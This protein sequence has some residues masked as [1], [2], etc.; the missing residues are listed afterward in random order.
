MGKLK[1]AIARP[2]AIDITLRDQAWRKRLAAWVSNVS[3]PP[4]ITSL[5]IWLAAERFATPGAWRWAWREWALLV[6]IP[7]AYVVWLA[8]RGHV[9][10][11]DVGVREQRMKPY[12][13]TVLCACLAFAWSQLDTTP[14]LLTLFAGAATAQVILLYLVTTRWKIS[15]HSAAIASCSV[16]AVAFSGTLG[17]LFVAGIPLVAWARVQLRRHTLAQTVA[18][19]VAGGLIYA[20]AL[21]VIH[22]R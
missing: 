19:A 18:G 16:V 4:V 21:F 15:V 12:R 5:G 20:A 11:L 6:I 9:T 22:P 3:S 17:L 1:L 10:D 2:A 14:Q 13:L 8:L 7:A